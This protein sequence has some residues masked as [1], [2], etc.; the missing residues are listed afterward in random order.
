MSYSIG[1]GMVTMALAGGLI[2]YF[3][4]RTKKNEIIHRERMTAME[5]GIPLPEFPGDRKSPGDPTVLPLLGIILF[6]LSIGAMIVLYLNLR[7]SA[8]AFWVAP[9]PFAFM[10]A[11]LLTFHLL[12]D[13]AWR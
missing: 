9:L 10:G 6:T 7:E 4:A 12:K 13:N 5:K 1:D 2:G 8:H 11:G 3:W